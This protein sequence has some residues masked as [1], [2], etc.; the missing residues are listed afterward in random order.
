[1]RR[2]GGQ[3][4]FK[5][6]VLHVNHVCDLAMVT[7]A[8]D[9]FWTD[10]PALE[11]HANVPAL[12]ERVMVMGYPM[13]GETISVTRGI[14]SRIT[15]LAYDES[16]SFLRRSPELLAVQIDAA[17][18]SGNSGGPVFREN[19]Q[20]IGVAFSGFA[21]S[22]DNIGWV[23]GWGCGGGGGGEKGVRW[24]RW[25]FFVFLRRLGFLSFEPPSHPTPLPPP[26]Y[27]IPTTVLAS[28]LESIRRLGKSEVVCDLG[29]S[30]ERC[31]NPTLQK[32]LCLKDGQTGIRVSKVD[33]LNPSYTK[34]AV[35]D[36]I[37]SINGN[38]VCHGWRAERMRWTAHKFQRAPPLC[39]PRLPLAAHRLQTTARLRF[40]V[41]SG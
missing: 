36:V 24:K 32:V 16:K 12:D 26:S 38:K 33:K 4:K 2:H 17:I 1:M 18:N 25:N 28:F 13:G 39:D 3:E 21:G 15:T 31:E 20:L 41:T 14:V 29:L 5:A 34:L 27:I 19:G 35:N 23:G 30:Y 6:Q 40:E 37:M 22:A 10:L 8:D 9:A 7:V 11:V